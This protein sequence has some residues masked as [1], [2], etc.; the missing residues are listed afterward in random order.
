[1]A[2]QLPEWQ[3]PS[4]NQLGI[5]AKRATFQVW[6]GS[7]IAGFASSAS[8]PSK[9]SNPWVQSLNGEWNF[10]Y[11]KRP[12]EVPNVLLT[13]PNLNQSWDKIPVPMNWQLTHRYDPPV[14]TN[15][16][17]PFKADSAPQVPTTYNPT[18]V[19]YRTFTVTPAMKELPLTLQFL[20]VQGAAT[21]YL[22]GQRL[23]HHED[24]MTT[25]E[26]DVTSVVKPG[27]N[28]LA[29]QVINFHD[30]AYLEDQDFWRL[31]GIYRSV[32]LVATPQVSLQDYVLKTT[33]DP[34]YRDA[35]L[36]LD[37]IFEN[38]GAVVAQ[39]YTVDVAVTRPLGGVAYS[40]SLPLKSII[41]TGR[42]TLSLKQAFTSP[43]LWSDETPNL[44]RLDISWK[45]ATGK[46]IGRVNK[47]F[48]FRQVELK[49]GQLLLNGQV[50]YFKGVNRHEFDMKLGRTC[51]RADMIKDIVLMKQHNINAVRTSHYPNDPL[52]YDLCDEYG[53]LVWDEANI[54][55]HELWAWRKV[56]V[57]DL[58][59]WRQ[60]ILER[61]MNMLYRDRNHACIVAWSMGNET[62]AG[63]NFDELYKSMKATDPTRPIHYESQNPAY[64]QKLNGYDIISTMYPDVSYMVKLMKQDPTRPAIFCEYAHTMGNSGGNLKEYWDTIYHY[65]RMQGAFIWDW[66][67]QGLVFP[68]KDGKGTF[69]EFGNHVDDTGDDGLINPDRTPEPELAEVKK[70]HQSIFITRPD[71]TKW[72]FRILN[73]YKFLN[74]SLFEFKWYL[75][76]RRNKA[77]LK[78]G[79]FSGVELEPG[80]S[81]LVTLP[82]TPQAGDV[83]TVHAILKTDMPWAPKGHEVAWEQFDLKAIPFTK[84]T[85]PHTIVEA[86]T[87]YLFYAGNSVV[88]IDRGS[89]DVTSIKRG[90]KELLAAALTSNFYRS[91]TNNDEGGGTRS[92][93]HAWIQK[94]LA[95]MKLESATVKATGP[96]IVVNRIWSSTGANGNKARF[97][98]RI[99][100]GDTWQGMRVEQEVM[101]DTGF[102]SLPRIGMQ[103]T[104]RP[105]DNLVRWW[106]RGPHETY[107][108]RKTG[109]KLGH[110]SARA[111][112]LEH[113]YIDPQENGNRADVEELQIGAVGTAPA[114]KVI[115]EG[116]HAFNFSVHYYPATMLDEAIYPYQI[117]R[118]KNPIIKLDY[119]QMGLGG[120]DSW[121]P[122]VHKEYRLPGGNTYRWAFRILP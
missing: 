45:D 70:V 115:A 100:Y 107:W 87:H 58:E 10:K 27:T 121:S 11:Y 50:V 73:D 20:G 82:I 60:S 79:K 23:G 78:T 101:A 91:P 118:G 40:T 21:F 51:S 75:T 90:G 64:A 88:K 53:L 35:E 3:D 71:T 46:V 16:R 39:G 28:H 6:P 89:G 105:E 48:G 2:Q 8:K 52:W 12:A 94:G 61:G 1:M 72:Q 96:S 102:A 57:G 117:K 113:D 116:G 15:I 55:S 7:S 30:G 103:M 76:S 47:P 77:A 19:Y 42:E 29:I 69:L 13:N 104:L 83:I 110:Y 92:I 34:K 54:E 56:Y 80:K 24:G 63:R 106:G 4:R 66:V 31:S 33:L 65:P 38:M 95:R 97:I 59:V 44:Y 99:T 74:T 14:F 18:G 120:D 41:Q 114:L 25:I 68:R 17:H 9:I 86:T 111:Q 22:N 108:D 43:A 81:M 93:A 26:F 112:D 37:L 98:E 62:G 49:N 32:N 122:R 36:E 67:N 109:A 119:Q 85:S 84:V 5:K